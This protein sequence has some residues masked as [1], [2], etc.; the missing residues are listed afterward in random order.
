RRAAE[1]AIIAVPEE[2]LWPP[3]QPPS[4][5]EGSRGH[6][7]VQPEAPYL[8]SQ[9]PPYMA[10]PPEPEQRFEQFHQPPPQPAPPPPAPPPP[11]PQ[12]EPL[13]QDWQPAAAHGLW[14]PPGAP[15]GNWAGGDSP[16]PADAGRRRARHSHPDQPLDGS[17]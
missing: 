3:R 10:P 17:R 9:E 2:P 12:P 13:T 4:P 5:R 7:D 8:V 16:G 1:E 11:P 15:G 6:Y 14:L